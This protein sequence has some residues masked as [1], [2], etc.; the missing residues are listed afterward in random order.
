MSYIFRHRDRYIDSIKSLCARGGKEFYG[1]VVKSGYNQKTVTV[2][3][4]FTRLVRKYKI[5]QRRYSKFHVHDPYD[6]C[7]V[8]DKVYIKQCMSISPIKHYFV[9][10]FFW[11]SPRMNFVINKFLPFEKEAL[12]Y[13]ENIQKNNILSLL[14]K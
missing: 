3:V 6:M 13:N 2:K 10:N 5:I 1:T 12:V 4:E 7:R 11:M 8:G 14:Q 9:R